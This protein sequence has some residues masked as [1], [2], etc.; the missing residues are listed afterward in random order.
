MMN[1]FFGYIDFS[2]SAMDAIAHNEPNSRL[3]REVASKLLSSKAIDYSSSSK[4]HDLD[5]YPSM[6]L[7]VGQLS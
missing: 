6:I 3:M 4:G 2:F 5:L 7:R 1:V